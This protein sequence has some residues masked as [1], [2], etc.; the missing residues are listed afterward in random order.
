MTLTDEIKVLMADEVM[1]TGPMDSKRT[2]RLI[3]AI[4]HDEFECFK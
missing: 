1:A 2:V 4:G 3:D